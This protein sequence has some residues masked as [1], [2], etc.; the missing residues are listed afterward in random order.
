MIIINTY[1][2]NI[3]TTVSLRKKIFQNTSKNNFEFL[4]K[5]GLQKYSIEKKQ[6]TI[7]ISSSSD[8]DHL[9][10]QFFCFF[11]NNIL[12]LK[13]IIC[14]HEPINYV[15]KLNQRGLSNAISDIQL[16]NYSQE[17]Y[18]KLYMTM[19]ISNKDE[20]ICD[21]LCYEIHPYADI[22]NKEP[23]IIVQKIIEKYE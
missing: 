13:Q 20:S 14:N 22:E 11:R 15:A 12:E 2:I 1:L 18:F 5:L 9:Y 17:H 21:N 6:E 4:V 19:T 23:E 10:N 3:N 8:K 7:K 16:T